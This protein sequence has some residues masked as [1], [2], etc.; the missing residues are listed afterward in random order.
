MWGSLGKA[1]YEG[2][3]C[4]KLIEDCPI[5]STDLKNAH[6]IFGPNL[7]GL[8][9][10][11]ARRKPKQVDMKIVAI[12]QGSLQLHKFIVLTADVMFVN[13]LPFL[14]IRLQGVKLIMI[15][16]LP[17][18]TSKI[19]GEKLKHILHFNNRAGSIVQMALM[20]KEFDAV[21]DQCTY[22]LINTTAAKEHMPEIECTVQ[23]VKDQAWGIYNTI[24]FPNGIPKL[25]MIALLH[26]IIL[27]LNAFPVNSGISTKFSPWELV[28]QH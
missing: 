13:G 22:L 24:P 26:F 15:D 27:W 14:L 11:T 12:L 20:D 3:V 8:R 28:L 23:T 18:H 21:K 4:D 10:W 9:G 16:Y 2:M 6:Q 25:I 19:I 17:R 1:D 5:D 7:A